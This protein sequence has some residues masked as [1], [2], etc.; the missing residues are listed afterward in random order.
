MNNDMNNMLPSV[1]QTNATDEN[2][3]TM[4]ESVIQEANS[5]NWVKQSF[6]KSR[7]V[8]QKK[9]T[10]L[11]PNGALIWKF[12]WSAYASA[13]D[14]TCSAL[15]LDGGVSAIDNCRLYLGGKLI[16]EVREVGQRIA[17]DN[18]FIP[19]DAQVEILDEKVSSNRQFSITT[20]GHTQ[21]SADKNNTQVGFRGINDTESANVECS[22]RL[23]QLFPVL[24]D[25]MLPSFLD[26]EIIV[27][28]D[29]NGRFTE[30][31]NEIADADA[32][33]TDTLRDV[34]V[35]RPRLHL[36]YITMADEV[37][38]ALKADIMGSTGMTI[39]YREQV[40]VKTVLNA[41]ATDNTSGSQ[42]VELGFNNRSVMKL[43]VQK[44][45]NLDNQLLR[46]TRSD[47]LLQEELQLV[48]NNRNIFDREVKKTSEMYSYLGQTAEKPSYLLAGSYGQVGRLGA[49]VNAV[50]NTFA[51][52]FQPPHQST[53]TTTTIANVCNNLQGR[54]RY[55]GINLGKVRNQDTPQNSMRIGESPMILRVNRNTATTGDEALTSNSA[56]SKGAYNMNVW[57]ECVKVLMLKNGKVDSMNL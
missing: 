24:K 3:S 54:K 12:K 14:R 35:V 21:L 18:S 36:N 9:G 15:K 42:D 20:G 46:K 30:C 31:F 7:F 32:V 10:A 23:D 48:V 49:D 13:T 51:D 37:A 11:A 25:T 28:I 29:W 39:P 16:S 6:G 33:W 22:V 44:Q 41:V 2:Q 56:E 38:N 45:S 52:T 53:A 27:E 19:Y 34:E 5:H 26:G 57:V 47:G 55:L 1:L 17:L 50:Q 4:V 40:L 43:Y 8:L